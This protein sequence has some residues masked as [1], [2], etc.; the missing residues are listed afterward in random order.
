MTIYKERK[1]QILEHLEIIK[2]HIKANGNTPLNEIHW[3]HVGDL[4]RIAEQLRELTDM[5]NRT[6]EYRP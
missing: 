5:I 1:A 3:G 4:G 2:K 6:G